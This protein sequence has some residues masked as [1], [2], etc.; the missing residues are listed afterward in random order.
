MIFGHAALASNDPLYGQQWG[1]QRVGAEEA[2]LTS[3]GSV[4]IAIVDTGVDQTHPDLQKIFPG[5]DFV[6]NDPDPQDQTGGR[7][8]DCPGNF[9]HGTHVAGIAAATA[10]NGVGVAGAAP[11]AKIMPVRAL[12]EHGCGT[13]EAISAGIRWASDHGAQVINLSLGEEEIDRYISG[14]AFRD[15]VE[16]AWDHGVVVVIAAGNARLPSGYFNIDA[17]IV[18]ATDE[19]DGQATFSNFSEAKWALTAPGTNIV[20]TVPGGF[21]RASGTSM[22]TPHVAG[23]AALLRCLGLTNEQT[24]FRLISTADDLGVPGKDPQFGYGRV[25]LARAVAGFAPHC[26]VSGLGATPDQGGS[27][28]ARRSSPAANRARPSPNPPL[29]AAG[30]PLPPSPTPTPTPTA[31]AASATQRGGGNVFFDVILVLVVLIL[32]AGVYLWNRFSR[33]RTEP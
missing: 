15:A 31:R 8:G 24:V 3:A 33:A 29:Q 21:A 12:N 18:G 13:A 17:L 6:A 28:S 4:L 2:W 20:S 23:A 19:N 11:N 26:R 1:M 7:E 22:A 25:N 5:W 14:S 27:S 16:Y 32:G 10:N 9:G 30:S